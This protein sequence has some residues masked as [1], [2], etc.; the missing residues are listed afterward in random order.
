MK[1]LK[2]W[3]IGEFLSDSIDVYERS[4]INLIYDLT[5]FVIGFVS[6]ICTGLIFFEMY[7][8][9]L[10]ASI[11]LFGLV[12]ILFVL[13]YKRN[14]KLAALIY[15]FISILGITVSLFVSS[16]IGLSNL[17]WFT[18]LIL[19]ATFTVGKKWAIISTILSLIPLIYYVYILMYDNLHTEEIYRLDNLNL[20]VMSTIAG[21]GVIIYISLQFVKTNQ[22]AEEQVKKANKHL[23]EQNNAKTT[24]LKEIHHRVKNNLQVINSLL[25][26]QG[27]EMFDD[28]A[29]AVFE[30]CQNR[31]ISMALIHEK[32]YQSENLSH[33]NAKVYFTVLIN[34]L[35]ETYNLSQKVT[36]N[37]NITVEQFGTKTLVPLG[38][39]VNELI[40]KIH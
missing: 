7:I 26:L 14:L 25:K 28:K 32:L 1:K 40:S 30:E 18:V 20:Q 22:I 2:H 39:I 35:I 36:A 10:P 34:D 27:N 17:I 6:F 9:I 4:K 37:I 8:N 24:L 12:S 11:I 23:T 31:V 3:F 21:F 29:Y 13:R 38:L 33:V 15:I 19:F 16:A 5:I